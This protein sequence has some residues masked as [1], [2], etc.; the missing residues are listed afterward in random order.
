MDLGVVSP[1]KSLG[2]V[3]LLMRWLR[4]LFCELTD[5]VSVLNLKMDC[6]V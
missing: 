1:P 4:I 5:G 6:D 2:S 3:A